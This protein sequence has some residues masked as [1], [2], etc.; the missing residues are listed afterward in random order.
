[1]KV[2]T[3]LYKIIIMALLVCT[4]SLFRV[5]ISGEDLTSIELNSKQASDNAYFDVANMFPGDGVSKTYNVK[6]SYKDKVKVIFN[7]VNNND[8]NLADVANIQ[9][10]LNGDVLYNGLVCNL[11]NITS[12]L[13]SN[14][15]K[16]EELNYEICVSLDT[17]VNSDYQN[18]TMKLDFVWEVDKEDAKNLVSPNTGYSSNKIFWVGVIVVCV[19][20]LLLIRRSDK[21]DR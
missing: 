9:V 7:I 12:T 2:R 19:G 21:N 6:V 5:A 17:S 3:R 14:N 10:K 11:K 8:S 1:M 20:L 13:E 18:S 15:S 4:S 16:S